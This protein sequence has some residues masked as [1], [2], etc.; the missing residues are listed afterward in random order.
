MRKEF[1]DLPSLFGACCK[2]DLDNLLKSPAQLGAF[3][4]VSKIINDIE[5][6]A[7]TA[8]VNFALRGT[9]IPGFTLVRHESPGYVETKTLSE[10]FSGCPLA[11]IPALVSAIVEMCGHIS[12]SRY[13]QLCAAIGISPT[14]AAIKHAGAAPF[15]RQNPSNQTKE[16]EG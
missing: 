7:R 3:L 10:L 6:E 8:A 11:R 4:L 13:R 9:E 5:P 12:S 16:R 2:F 15:L 14:E 1:G